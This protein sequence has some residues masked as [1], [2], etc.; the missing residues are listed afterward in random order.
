MSNTTIVTSYFQ[1]NQSKSSHE[2]YIERMK[3]ML[4]INNPMVIY[5]DKHSAVFIEEFR[6]KNGLKEK[7]IVIP[8]SF[9]EFYSIK[10]I[11][12]F[13]KH[14][15]MDTEQCIGHNEFLYMVWAEKSHFV[16][17]TA[18]INPF[19][20]D[21]FI[22]CDIGCFRR[23]NRQFIHW[24]NPEKI[25][26][27]D[28]NK[29]TLLSVCPFKEHELRCNKIEELPS[30][31]FDDRIGGTI[32]SGS[33][34]AINQ[35]HKLYYEMLE[36]FI[37]INRFIGKDQ[38]IMNSVYLLNRDLCNLVNRKPGGDEWLYL[39]DYFENIDA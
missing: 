8:T 32:F 30:F 29:I 2:R 5:C 28:K 3:N 31:Q 4:I 13:M 19:N 15:T 23:S 38:S 16:K 20:S 36:H 26:V 18:D 35:W 39:Q 34:D 14:Y 33:I 10:Y 9:N 17:R 1:L 22:W 27:L 25:N 24:P 6:T 11:D 21:Y 37:S 7:T 12:D